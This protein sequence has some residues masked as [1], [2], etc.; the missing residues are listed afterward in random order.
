LAGRIRERIEYHRQKLDEA[1]TALAREVAG[2]VSHRD[3][4]V[5]LV[6]RREQDR[7]R[8]MIV[9]LESL[10]RWDKA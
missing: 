1:S 9:E 5:M 3:M 10:L 4:R 6:L 7:H 8:S 2:A